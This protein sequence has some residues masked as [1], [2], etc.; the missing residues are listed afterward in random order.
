MTAYQLLWPPPRSHVSR[1]CRALFIFGVVLFVL[2]SLITFVPGGEQNWF[3]LSA[4]FLAFGLA[5]ASRAQVWTVAFLL[6]LAFYLSFQGY[7]QGVAYE[8]WLRQ[9]HPSSPLLHHP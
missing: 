9:H 8:A 5:P 4:V 2:G 6:A 1:F 3:L 7:K